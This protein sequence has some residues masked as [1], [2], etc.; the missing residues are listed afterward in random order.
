M[1]KTQGWELSLAV[2]Y[3]PRM[4]NALGSIPVPYTQEIKAQIPCK[5]RL[6]FI[7]NSLE[8]EMLSAPRH[9]CSHRP[10]QPPR[11]T[12]QKHAPL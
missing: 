7:Y 12:L 1:L 5:S 6:T 8:K 4:C 3:L 10:W 11:A 9:Q 2:E